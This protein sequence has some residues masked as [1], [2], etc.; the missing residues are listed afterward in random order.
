M[1]DCSMDPNETAQKLLLQDPFHEVRRMRDH[2]KEVRGI[3]ERLKLWYGKVMCFTRLNVVKESTE[4]RWKPG[5]QGRGSRGGRG[6]YSSRH[7]SHDAGSNKNA[8]SGKESEINHVADDGVILP[9]PQ[10]KKSKEIT[11][12]PSSCIVA[13]KSSTIPASGINESEVKILT[14]ALGDLSASDSV[15]MPSQDSQPPVGTISLEV[16]SQQTPLEK[17]NEDFVK[18]ESKTAS[19]LDVGSSFMQGKM[20]QGDGPHNRPQQ[21]IGPYKVAPVKEWKP[22]L[23]NPII[24]AQALV[25]EVPAIPIS[26]PVEA[27][28][29]STTESGIPES[30][31]SRNHLHVPEAEKLG[32][33]FGS[34]DASF[35]LNSN[36]LS[37]PGGPGPMIDEN[38]S[39]SEA[40]EETTEHIEEQTNRDQDVLATADDGNNL[41]RP[42]SSVDVPEGDVSYNV[43]PEHAESKQ[44]TSLPVP[45]HQ[46][47]VVHPSSNIV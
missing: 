4:T 27:P 37:G 33:C 1:K 18:I 17:V 39:I 41:D 45:G 5:M 16:G 2:K 11:V 28:P 34:F 23:T 40:F 24:P 30:K 44:E 14:A 46:Y 10:D 42:P 38:R 29:S 19:V 35:G 13:E 43:G 25:T 7:N 21:V 6:N 15:L 47:P 36:T 12:V 26:V 3:S 9:A 31:E 22:K 8:P 20:F 32:F